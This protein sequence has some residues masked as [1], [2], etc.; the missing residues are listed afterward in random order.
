MIEAICL[1]IE[2][3][4]DEIHEAAKTYIVDMTPESVC[5][6]GVEM[7]RSHKYNVVPT[8]VSTFKV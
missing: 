2:K 8:L 1:I 6:L 5:K 7:E 3:W 4:F